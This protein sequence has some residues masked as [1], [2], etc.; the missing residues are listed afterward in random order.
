MKKWTID[1]SKELYNIL[2]H[3]ESVGFK[4]F[5]PFITIVAGRIATSHD[6]RELHRHTGVGQLRHHHCLLSGTLL[7]GDDVVGKFIL[8]RVVGHIQQSEGDLS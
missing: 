3:G 7:E 8:L 4:H 2:E 6:M 1:D 5:C